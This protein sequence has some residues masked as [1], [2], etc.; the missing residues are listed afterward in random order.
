[1]QLAD[2]HG[3]FGVDSNGYARVH[4]SDEI[5]FLEKAL[6]CSFSS[7]RLN[8]SIL[9]ALATGK[10]INLGLEAMLAEFGMELEG[11]LHSGADDSRNIARVL[12]RLLL[13]SK[14]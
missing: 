1:M 12:L 6:S 7:H 5:P 3:S 11:R 13:E 8:V 4:A 14:R 10:D 2:H 9:F